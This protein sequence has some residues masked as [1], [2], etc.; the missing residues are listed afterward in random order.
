MKK[1][2]AILLALVLCL[3]TVSAL[4]DLSDYNIVTDA[5][6]TKVILDTDMGYF[7]DDTYCMFILLQADAAGWIDLLGISSV[8]ANVTTAEGTCAILNQLEYL[9]RT[10]VPVYIGCDQPLFG[11]RTEQEIATYGL[12]RISSMTKAI[13]Y[14]DKIA[15][16]DLGDLANAT[17]GYPETSAPQEIPAWQFFINAA[18]E[19]PGQLWIL[20]IGACTNVAKAVLAD[21]TFAADCAGIIYMGGAIDVPGND[22]PC[23]ERNWYYDVESVDICLHAGFPQQIIVPNDISYYQKLDYDKVKAMATSGDTIYNKAVTEFALPR[24]ESNPT[25]QQSLWDA[26]TAGILVCPDLISNT[27]NR[28]VVMNTNLGYTYGESVAWKR[29]AP[30]TAVECKI[31]YDVDGAAYWD[32]VAQL[33]GTD[34]TK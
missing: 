8:G 18:H 2:L 15:W 27:D 12:T 6:T 4:A 34:F 20:A 9:G 24:F 22:T 23:A 32:F 19:N 11:F 14:K 33:F 29:N 5:A 1:V 10:D 28:F 31:V 21:P 7:G 3:G 16:N 17:W 13:N 26:Q 25:R 30:D